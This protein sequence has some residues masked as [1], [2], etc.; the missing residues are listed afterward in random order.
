MTNERQ[1]GRVM[2]EQVLS[3]RNGSAPEANALVPA[4]RAAARV[5]RQTVVRTVRRTMSIELVSE[6][7]A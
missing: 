3:G 2:I 5:A 7:P 6:V 4:V 1:I